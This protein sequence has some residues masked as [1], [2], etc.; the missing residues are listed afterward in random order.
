VSEL[1]IRLA[2]LFA[3][4]YSLYFLLRKFFPPSRK[5]SIKNFEITEVTLLLVSLP[6]SGTNM[7]R[8]CAYF[9]DNQVTMKIFRCLFNDAVS[10]E[11]M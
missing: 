8:P 11:I 4:V 7:I 5:N 1:F 6:F 2:I 10:I 9:T 3:S